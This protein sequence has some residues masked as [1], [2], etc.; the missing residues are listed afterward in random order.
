MCIVA[1]YRGGINNLHPLFI[2]DR[3]IIIHNTKITIMYD[4]PPT[5]AC[6]PQYPF[7]VSTLLCG[8]KSGST[9]WCIVAW[10]HATFILADT[11][12]M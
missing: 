8:A 10:C 11:V 5:F 12:T 4:T 1:I 3:I 9:G 6:L 7:N 2:L